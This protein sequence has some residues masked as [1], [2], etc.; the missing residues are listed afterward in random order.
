MKKVIS[1]FLLLFV[2]FNTFANDTLLYSEQC[3]IKECYFPNELSNFVS[4][5]TYEQFL[6]DIDYICYYLKFAYA[7]YESMRLRG[8]EEEEFKAFLTKIA[9][10]PS[11]R[12]G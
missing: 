8:F 9:F 6:K 12:F 11:L 3:E 5:I 2:S 1:I 4:E 7:G 10:L